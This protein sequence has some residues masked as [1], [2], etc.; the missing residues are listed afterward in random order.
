MFAD[1]EYHHEGEYDSDK[2]FDSDDSQNVRSAVGSK[3]AAYRQSLQKDWQYTDEESGNS[4]DSSEEEDDDED[5][6]FYG[7]PKEAW[8]GM[9]PGVSVG[10]IGPMGKLPVFDVDEEGGD[11]DGEEEDGEH[12]LLRG[13]P[14]DSYVTRLRQ[15]AMLQYLKS[16]NKRRSRLQKS[17]HARCWF[18]F[19]R[20]I[21]WMM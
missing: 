16:E 6:D 1:N 17:M 2:E 18:A 15:Q 4:D 19:I 8:R 10:A 11:D 3:V 5:E 12:S 14:E 9:F 21:V 7:Y 20:L 13:L